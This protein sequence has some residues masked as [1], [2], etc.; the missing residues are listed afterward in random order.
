MTEM[1]TRAEIER[2]R[3]EARVGQAITAARAVAATPE[4][5]ELQRRSKGKH[6]GW[7]AEDEA[8]LRQGMISTP[9]GS[10]R[11]RGAP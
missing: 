9:G 7:T 3:H 2:E 11:L 5:K 6:G 1:K 10:Y 8:R 4:A